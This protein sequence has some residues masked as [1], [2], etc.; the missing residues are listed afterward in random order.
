MVNMVENPSSE[1]SVNPVGLQI[2]HAFGVEN[3]YLLR[4]VTDEEFAEKCEEMLTD[5]KTTV[6]DI[7]TWCDY[8]E[9]IEDTRPQLY[10]SANVS[11]KDVRDR[12]GSQERSV[13][14][15]VIITATAA[16]SIAGSTPL[17]VT[18][19]GKIDSEQVV[20]P[21]SEDSECDNLV[22][23]KDAMRTMDDD[24]DSGTI[25]GHVDNIEPKVVK[26]VH[27]EN[28]DCINFDS[29]LLF[30][31]DKPTLA[32]P[33]DPIVHT[34]YQNEVEPT[35]TPTYIPT[36]SYATP[37]DSVEPNDLVASNTIS[38]SGRNVNVSV[39]I[40]NSYALY[41]SIGLC[42]VVDKCLWMGYDNCGDT[43]GHSNIY[44]VKNMVNE[45]KNV[46]G[47]PP[48]KFALGVP[49]YGENGAETQINYF[50][51][52]EM[53]ADPKGNGSFA[54]YFFD[55]QPILQEKID[56]CNNEGLGGLMAFRLRCDLLPED[57]RSLIYAIKQKLKPGP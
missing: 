17:T 57:T 41:K 3:V 33:A 35:S 55:S 19:I 18:S 5:K 42:G 34:I 38:K 51:L 52:V 56:L 47:L 25:I 10:R 46:Q 6:A 16:A 45:W 2:A 30:L 29:V 54:G 21:V 50:Q 39:A 4:Y 12:M 22:C 49:L 20:H 40:G 53:G 44:W 32:V 36:L 7:L 15:D 11:I 28:R 27:P 8:M 24:D 14:D 43:R 23:D 1:P 9:S 13:G 26:V 31:P 48:A 37:T